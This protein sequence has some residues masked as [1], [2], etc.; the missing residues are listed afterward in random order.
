MS[1]SMNPTLVA[2]DVRRRKMLPAK[3]IRLLPSAAAKTQRASAA[4]NR[5]AS[6]AAAQ[7]MPAAVIAC[8]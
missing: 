6:I 3:E 8:R 2:D 1:L 4:S 7:P 5:S